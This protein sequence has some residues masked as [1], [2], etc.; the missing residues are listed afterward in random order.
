MDDTVRKLARD[1][2]QKNMVMDVDTIID[3]KTGEVLDPGV[4]FTYWRDK[5]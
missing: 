3:N 4:D 1:G 5:F 2:L